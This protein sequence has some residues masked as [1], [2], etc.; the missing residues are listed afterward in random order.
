M[1]ALAAHMV[2]MRKKTGSSI[3]KKGDLKNHLLFIMDEV[4]AHHDTH[5]LIYNALVSTIGYAITISS[6]SLLS[7]STHYLL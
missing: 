5:C 6:Y 4:S 1:E 7:Q 2:V 3:V